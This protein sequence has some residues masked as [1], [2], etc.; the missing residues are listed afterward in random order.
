MLSK[1]KYIIYIISL[2]DYGEV[3]DKIGFISSCH[4]L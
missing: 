1:R 4:V 3:S 2:D